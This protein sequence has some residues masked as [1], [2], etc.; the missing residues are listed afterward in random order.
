MNKREIKA[1]QK[2]GVETAA[3][4]PTPTKK[5]VVAAE[6]TAP[7]KTVFEEK[8]ALIVTPGQEVVK[9]EKKPRPDTDYEPLKPKKATSAY[10]FFATEYSAILRN[11]KNYSVVDAIKGAGVAWNNLKDTDKAKYEAMSKADQERFKKQTE[12]MQAKGYFTL[13]DGSKSTDHH[14]KLKKAEKK[15][16]K[17]PCKMRGTQTEK[18]R[19]VAD[20]TYADALRLAR[21]LAPKKV[22]DTPPKSGTV[23]IMT[24]K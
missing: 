8:K 3:R 9:K 7:V 23:Q 13:E 5:V 4:S 12:E 19:I 14:G 6:K 21:E 18:V 22:E 2:A 17:A 24:V 11:E 15:E 10:M 16:I 20:L 1:E